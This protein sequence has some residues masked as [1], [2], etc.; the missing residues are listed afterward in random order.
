[1]IISLEWLRAYVDMPL[2]L[3]Q[4]A[5]RLTMVGLEVEAVHGGDEALEHIVT[6]RVEVVSPHPNADKLHL[7]DVWDGT[8]TRRVVCG[9]PNVAAGQVAPL[10]L[11]GA[12][13]PSGL[14]IQAT[15]IRGQGSEGMLCSQKE[16]GLGDDS[17]GIWVLPP[18]TPVG[19]P[20]SIALGRDDARLEIGVTPNRGDCLSHVG[21]AREVAAICGTTLR[22]PDVSLEEGGPPIET[23]AAVAIHDPIGCPRYAARVIEGVRIGPSPDWLRRALEAAGVRSINNIVDVTNYVMMELGQP[24]HAFDYDLLREHRIVVR[25]AAAGETFTTLDGE[26][27]TLFDDTLLICDGVGPVAVA[28]IMGGLESEITDQ[29][30]RVLLESAYFDPTGIRRS[31]KKLGLRSESSFRFERGVDPEGTLRAVDRAAQLMAMVGGGVIAQG[32][33]DAHPNPHRPVSLTLRVA[34]TNRFLGTRLTAAQMAQALRSIEIDVTGEHA[35][36]LRV[37]VPSFRPDITREV[38]LQEEIARRVGFDQIPVTLPVSSLGGSPQDPYQRARQDVKDLLRGVGLTEVIT[39]SFIGEQ[40]LR[41]LNLGPDDP[42]LRPV[43][44]RNPLSEEQAVMRTSLVPGILGAVCRNFDHRN[45]DLRIFELSKVFIPKAGAPL[46]DEPHQLVGALSGKRLPDPLYGQ[47]EE[48]DFADAKGVVDLVLGAFHLD[49]VEYRA[50]DIPPYMDARFGASA[51][52]GEQRFGTLGPLHPQVADAFDIR[53][54]LYL[55]ELDFDRLFALRKPHPRYRPLPRYPEVARDMAIVLDAGVPVLE[56][57][58]Y[59]KELREPLLE[60]IEV[61]DIFMHERLGKNKRSLGYRL[62]YRAPDRSLTDD[63]VNTLHGRLTEK[64]LKT[65]HATL[66]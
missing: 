7:C 11:P 32:R 20:L 63:E 43:A 33:I 12:R 60:Q 65:F 27:R 56:P 37:E 53:R 44:I 47:G 6:A 35:D 41:K 55:F 64:V 22:Y 3:E 52:C 61:F 57:L 31:S 36:Q 15:Q 54:P 50:A 9:A 59:M 4:L 40:G 16:L 10:A 38:D 17:S 19:R 23:L 45:D 26:T 62:V 2:N 5:D 24:L 29:T 34:R 49:D 13:L 25:L 46:P 42:R 18:E 8:A 39:Y 14:T 30:T 48:V 66:R 21:I 28:G 51:Y 1:M 58:T